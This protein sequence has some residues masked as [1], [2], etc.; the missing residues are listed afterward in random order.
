MM[1]QIMAVQESSEPLKLFISQL[2][3]FSDTQTMR[4]KG[5]MLILIWL[6]SSM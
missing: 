2:L 1:T 6:M 5:R 4:V 3:N